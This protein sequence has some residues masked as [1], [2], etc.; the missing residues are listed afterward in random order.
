[1][2]DLI[3]NKADKDH[4][5]NRI[6]QTEEIL[7]D[8]FKN[9]SISEI[10]PPALEDSSLFKR[11]GGDTSDIGFIEDEATTRQLPIESVAKLIIAKADNQKF[12]IRKLERLRVKTQLAIAS[13]KNKEDVQ[14]LRQKL[15]EETFLSMLM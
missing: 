15:G 4:E 12:L 1:M 5:A 10:R 8:V 13:V 7:R 11:S 2:M 6:F 3:A 14:E 9:Y